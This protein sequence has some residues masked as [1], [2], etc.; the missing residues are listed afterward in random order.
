MAAIQIENPPAAEPVTLAQAKSHLR[1]TITDDDALIALDR[2]DFYAV[3]GELVQRIRRICPQVV[4]TIGSE[5]AVT[6]QIAP[7]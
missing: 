4:M 2:V 3:V 6:A 5:G 7:R 1:V